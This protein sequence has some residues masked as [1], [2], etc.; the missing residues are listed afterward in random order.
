VPETIEIPREGWNNFFSRF[1]R[2]HETQFVAVEVM[3]RDIGAQVEG[4]SLL[5]NGISKADEDGNSLAL[6]FDALDG[7]HLT[8]M[9]SKPSRVRVQRAADKTEQA[10]EI[11]SADG[12]TTLVRFPAAEAHRADELIGAQ[13]FPRKGDEE[14]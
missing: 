8:H 6:M 9:V 7:E 10:L 14:P 1:S 5:L 4:R 13:R 3:G 11:Q 2:D 12:T